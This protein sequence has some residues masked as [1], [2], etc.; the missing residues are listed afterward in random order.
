MHWMKV[1]SFGEEM[2]PYGD[3]T[4]WIWSQQDPSAIHIPDIRAKQA[5]VISAAPPD[6]LKLAEKEGLCHA[7]IDGGTTIRQ[8]LKCGCVDELILT[9]VP[10]LLGDGVPLFASGANEQK[11]LEHVQTTA[12]SNG[13]VQSHY[14]MA[15]EA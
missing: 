4:I 6:I 5:N 13:L 3:R 12:Y 11:R 7:Y 14:R 9:R 15:K 10:L 8:F 1:V 2:W